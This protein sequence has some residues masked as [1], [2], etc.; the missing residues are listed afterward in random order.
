M[1]TKS[2]R[3]LWLLGWVSFFNEIASQMVYPLIPK[4]LVSL[5]ATPA[6]IGLIEGIAESTASL[7]KSISGRLSDRWGKRKV[8]VFA[9][10]L[11]AGIT[12]PA[13]AFAGGWGH[14]LGLRF[15]DRMGKAIRGPARDALLSASFDEE[16]KGK[17]F[18]IQRAM[19]KG[20]AI[21]GPLIA[22]GILSLPAG[23]LRLV[24]L[25]A[26]IPAALSL[27]FI[28]FVKEIQVS[29]TEA[30]EPKNKV[31][32]FRSRP[33]RIFF[34]ANILFAL[35]NSSNAFLIL[36][37]DEAG[38]G[39]TTMLVL[40]WMI[41]NTVCV[42]ASPI[43]GSLSDRIGRRSV[44]SMSFL[45]YAALYGVFAFASA[46]WSIWLLFAAYGIYYGLSAGVFK[47]YIADLVPAEQRGTAY[48]YLET[49]VGLALLPASLIAG[50]AWEMWGS[51]AAFLISA[52]F[53]V[54]G[55]WVFSRSFL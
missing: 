22:L 51:A 6:A 12:K 54:V 24:F 50:F 18:G 7:F 31:S 27:L 28:P 49:G 37:A 52:G 2:N 32:P 10:Y 41:Y 17:S 9:G 39:D 43:L 36:K 8:F 47:A 48:G 21:L 3:T 11:L 19:D 34:F 42:I 26:A 55:F 4:F 53:A 13:M 46:S 40:L 33:F 5:G 1:S 38:L 30:L 14:V 44:I 29:K 20:G 23:N 25:L 35:G 15:T 45:Y 16:K